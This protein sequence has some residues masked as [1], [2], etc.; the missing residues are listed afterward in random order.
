MTWNLLLNCGAQRDLAKKTIITVNLH[1]DDVRV[2]MQTGSVPACDRAE[3]C[4]M[5][6][7]APKR[8]GNTTQQR[9]LAPMDFIGVLSGIGPEDMYAHV[10]G[11]L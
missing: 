10:D 5:V 9:L 4:R 1:I 6:G 2:R 11:L 3:D 7:V 8:D